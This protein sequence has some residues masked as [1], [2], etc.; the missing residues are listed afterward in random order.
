MN[1]ILNVATLGLGDETAIKS[2]TV[3]K[4][5]HGQAES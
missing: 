2:R 4:R 3:G 5:G 1:I